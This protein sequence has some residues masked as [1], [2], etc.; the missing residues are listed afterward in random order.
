[1]SFWTATHGIGNKEPKRAFRFKVI[2][3]GLDA[4]GSGYVWFAKKV[5]KPNYEISEAEHKFLT[6]TFYYPGRVTWKEIELTLVDPVSP[7]A[8]AQLNALLDAQGYAIPGSAAGPWETMSKGKGAAALG[9]IEIHQIDS[10]GATIEKWTLKN[11]FIK[12][13]KYGDLDYSSEDI[14]EMTLTLRYDWA[15][16]DIFP[17]GGGGVDQNVGADTSKITTGEA[18]APP[19]NSFFKTESE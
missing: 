1:M 17:G 11:P 16:C 3:N 4:D 6:H 9:N 14:I 15:T 19:T 5:S 12:G 8:M 2:I 13:V 10:T 18:G 7:G